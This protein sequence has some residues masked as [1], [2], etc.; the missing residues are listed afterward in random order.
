MKSTLLF[1]WIGLVNLSFA[2]VKYSQL[3]DDV[4]VKDMKSFQDHHVLHLGHIMHGELKEFILNC[5]EAYCM[6]GLAFMNSS[7]EYEWIYVPEMGSI[8]DFWEDADYIYILNSQGTNSK[9]NS[10]AELFLLKLD[11]KG[12]LIGRKKIDSVDFNRPNG[13]FDAK[14]DD[15]G[16]IWKITNIPKEVNFSDSKYR[17]GTPGKSYI[18]E[19]LSLNLETKVTYKID[20]KYLYF[21]AFDS[22]P[23]EA[24]FIF[25]ADS[26]SINYELVPGD[27]NY[28][29]NIP[30]ILLLQFNLKGELMTSKYIGSGSC[31]IEN[32]KYQGENLIIGGTYSGNDS[33]SDLPDCYFQNIR[34]RSPKNY[35]GNGLV[36]NSFVTSID[37]DLN[38]NWLNKIS[39]TSDILFNS[40]SATGN[41]VAIS[42][43]YKDSVKI[44]ES[45]FYALKKESK[46]QYS[47]P[48]IC[49][50]NAEGKLT[51]NEQLACYSSGWNKVFLFPNYTA[52]HG[53]FLYHLEVF[54]NKLTSESKNGVYYFTI[55][56]NEKGL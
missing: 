17:F 15:N 20:G 32:M 40:L 9:V 7:F 38:V 22:K 4:L 21:E 56:E 6:D 34:L 36:R 46:Y 18:I 30:S 11:K 44:S 52:I 13:S 54:K 1:I 35:T 28:A 2:Q 29:N 14:F 8:T 50:F 51:F 49:F 45:T 37:S 42:F 10:H 53:E 31:W 55:I 3:F 33:I 12:E 47:D 19:A 25:S 16:L 24:S 26:T 43:N 41:T 48:I 27:N 23:G 5:D 39:A